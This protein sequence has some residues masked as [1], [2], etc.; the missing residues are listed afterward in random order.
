[1]MKSNLINRVNLRRLFG[2]YFYFIYLP[3]GLLYEMALVK[4]NSLGRTGTWLTSD[5]VSAHK[6]SDTLFILGSGD[7]INQYS[8]EQWADVKNADSF[9]INHWLLHPFVPT[10][11]AFENSKPESRQIYF[12]NFDQVWM[13]YQ[14]TLMLYKDG[15]RGKK[16]FEMVP[17]RFRDKLYIL[18]NPSLPI[19]S[20]NQLDLAMKTLDWLLKSLNH[21]SRFILF[22]KRASLLTAIEFAQVAGYRKIV[23]CGIDLNTTGFF[24]DHNRQ[25]LIDQGFLV[26][27]PVHLD[28]VHKTENPKHGEVTISQLIRKYN[29]L[30]LRKAG[31]QLY[32]GSPTSALAQDL[33][34]YWESK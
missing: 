10:Y 15:P 1:M 21:G 18:N 27:Q 11:Y 3:V 32:I 20:A 17:I 28:G 12:N 26:P 5:L 33:P 25:Q 30:V 34:Y 13:R 8:T 7:S 14:N 23:L 29:E 22:R 24:Y 31:I 16:R 19:L 2:K 4:I 6:K 9:G